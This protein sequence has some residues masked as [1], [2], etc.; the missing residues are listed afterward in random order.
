MHGLLSTHSHTDTHILALTHTDDLPA[1]AVF[2]EYL[3]CNPAVA[4]LQSFY[5]LALILKFSTTY[6]SYFILLHTAS[7]NS[8]SS[9]KCY[10][11]LRKLTNHS[12]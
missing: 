3:M 7:Q 9:N 4:S 5:R 1:L 6:I 10:C 2:K 8:G 11:G 12:I